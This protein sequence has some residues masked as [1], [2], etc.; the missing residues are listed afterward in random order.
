MKINR[1]VCNH[2]SGGQKIW[3]SIMT[4]MSLGI[5]RPC[6]MYACTQ[7]ESFFCVGVPLITQV[8]QGS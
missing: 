7:R 6:I 2:T 3:C 8:S 5:L 4:I 1:K